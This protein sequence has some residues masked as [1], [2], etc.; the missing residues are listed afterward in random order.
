VI[1]SELSFFVCCC[2]R[3]VSTLACFVMLVFL[4]FLRAPIGQIVF[5]RSTKPSTPTAF[6][7]RLF[8]MFSCRSLSM[9]YSVT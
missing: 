5:F 9:F 8:L 4:Y 6:L 7:L 3:L 2:L 1:A